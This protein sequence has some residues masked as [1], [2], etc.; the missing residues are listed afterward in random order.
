MKTERG[1]GGVY[2]VPVPPDQYN[3]REVFSYFLNL[4]VAK[5]NELQESSFL[6]FK[7]MDEAERRGAKHI[8]FDK[9]EPSREHYIYTMRQICSKMDDLLE[10]LDSD[11]E[12]A[13]RDLCGR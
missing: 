3:Q 10:A 5:A 4:I 9:V 1:R 13:G 2:R 11:I 7:A 12:L 6:A 8:N